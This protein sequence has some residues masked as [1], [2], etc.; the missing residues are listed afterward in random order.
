LF[1]YESDELPVAVYSWEVEGVSLLPRRRESFCVYEFIHEVGGDWDI[2][3]KD[4]AGE[5]SLEATGIYANEFRWGYGGVGPNETSLAVL[6]HYFGESLHV[7]RGHHTNPIG[8]EFVPSLA[9]SYHKKVKEKL[10]S[11]FTQTGR[12]VVT[13]ER[14]RR[15]LDEIDEER[16]KK[17]KRWNCLK[18]YMWGIVVVACIV[19]AFSVG[20]YDPGYQTPY[21]QTSTYSQR[22]L[23][24]PDDVYNDPQGHVFP[25][26]DTYGHTH[27]TK[28]CTHTSTI[29]RSSKRTSYRTTSSCSSYYYS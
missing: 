12:H 26:R 22:T 2:L 19:F 23:Y 9:Y 11:R 1:L 29:V 3:V 16:S 15:V 21:V 17:R 28:T 7:V 6:R 5:R 10:L 8:D 27:K 20:C 25:W 13:S 14:I 4:A 24:N 18:K